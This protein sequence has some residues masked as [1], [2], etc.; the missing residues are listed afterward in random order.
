MISMSKWI[1]SVILLTVLIVSVDL[2]Y[3]LKVLSTVP[4]I[5][6]LYINLILLAAIVTSAL[7]WKVILNGYS[8]ADV[9]AVSLESFF[10]SVMLPSSVAGDIAKV[11]LF[12]SVSANSSKVGASVVL[13]KLL[14][15]LAL[16]TVFALV[17]VLSTQATGSRFVFPTLALATI[18]VMLLVFLRNGLGKRMFLRFC[19]ILLLDL[20]SKAVSGALTTLE[21]AENSWSNLWDLIAN[22]ALSMLYQFLFGLLYLFA[23]TAV[24]ARLT[25]LDALTVSTVVQIA[26]LL[27]LSFAGLGAKDVA[28]VSVMVL[29]GIDYHHATAATLVL[30]PATLLF[31][32]LGWLTIQYRH[33]RRTRRRKS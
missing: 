26:N 19:T 17:L 21:Y 5:L 14:G 9:F 8:T 12:K 6:Y 3:I 13:D 31:A 15:L 4:T 24:G 16:T 18:V 25:V 33:I 20:N 7:K 11:Y 23:A 30:Y 29:L 27:P 28:Q 32:V 2:S 10:Y 1:V 22:F